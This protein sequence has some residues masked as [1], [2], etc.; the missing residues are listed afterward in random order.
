MAK[1]LQTE[2]Q[3]LGPSQIFAHFIAPEVA[4]EVQHLRTM[5]RGTRNDVLVYHA[6]YGEPE[7]TR[8]LLD[9]PETIVLLYHN[10]TPSNLFLA[11]EPQ[12]A[13]GLQWGRHELC[14]LRD[15]VVLTVAD[16][17]YNASDLQAHGF[18]DIHVIPAGLRPSRLHSVQPDVSLSR[19]LRHRF[20]KGFVLSVSQ[21]L[22]HKRFEDLIAAMH[23]AQWV[24][25]SELGLVIVGRARMRSYSDSLHS[26]ARL[27]NVQRVWFSGSVDDAALSTLYRSASTF[28]MT[29]IHEGLAVPPLE[30]MSFGVPVVARA[31]GALAETIA[32]AGLVLPSTAGPMMVS[33]AIVE[34][35]RNSSLRQDLAQRGFARVVEIEAENPGAQFVA[36][37]ESTLLR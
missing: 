23:L 20:P 17:S 3:R 4:C 22:P 21:L 37:L 12:F 36:L 29:S 27:L 32:N 9:R 33:E 24:S 7:V 11:H 28:A 31:A 13:A 15:R 34:L 16:S 30:A 35:D 18:E 2:L 14:L 5:P 1:A 10:I 25:Q 26:F 8:F 19:D 6:S